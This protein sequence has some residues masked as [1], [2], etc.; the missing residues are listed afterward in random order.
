MPTSLPD[1]RNAAIRSRR[2][3]T[4][5]S[6][7]ALASAL[8]MAV[9]LSACG[10]Q[11]GDTPQAASPAASAGGGGSVASKPPAPSLGSLV[12]RMEAAWSGVTSYR[13]HF[14]GSTVANAPGPDG[15]TP[16]AALPGPLTIEQEFASPDRRRQTRT[17]S[18][19]DDHEAIVDGPVLYLRGPLTAEAAPGTPPGAWI[20]M[21]A[22]LITPDTALGHILAGFVAPP[23]SPLAGVGDNLRPQGMRD[24]GPRDADGGRTCRAWGVA[25]TTDVGARL[26]VTVAVDGKDLPCL[27]E[28]RVGSEVVS[29]ATYDNWGEP[30]EIAIPVGAIA[31]TPVL[32][33]PHA[34]D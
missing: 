10:Q 29:T 26:D 6:A 2:S 11:P 32:G 19:A 1:R 34:H 27:L 9:L 28:T 22:A 8:A 16:L 23:R 13:G 20:V 15:G 12:D 17:G 25:D 30:I 31:V 3:A 24:L 18:G 4:P 33:E 5:L 14:T 7:A 21:P